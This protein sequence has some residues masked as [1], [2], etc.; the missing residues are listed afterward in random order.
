MLFTGGVVYLPKLRRLA[1]GILSKNGCLI[2][3]TLE[4]LVSQT[5]LT[6]L[7]SA[8]GPGWSCLW[9]RTSTYFWSTRTDSRDP[10]GHSAGNSTKSSVNTD[11]I[12]P[13]HIH[14]DC[15]AVLPHILAGARVLVPQE[16][17]S[18]EVFSLCSPHH[19]ED[20]NMELL[21]DKSPHQHQ[22]RQM[23]IPLQHCIVKWHSIL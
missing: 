13:E 20:I 22:V 6:D 9:A 4:F 3:K 17:P 12:Y 8:L 11:N 19:A 5:S 1:K 2:K 23:T 18:L 7:T 21:S 10:P 15:L 14:L 16:P